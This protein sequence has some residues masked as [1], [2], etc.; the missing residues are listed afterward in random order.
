[1]KKS[2]TNSAGFGTVE[3]LLIVLLVGII[4]IAGWKV[5]DSNK[6]PTQQAETPKTSSAAKITTTYINKELGFK[7]VY[8]KKWGEP[9]LSTNTS[10]TGTSYSI[11]IYPTATNTTNKVVDFWLNSEDYT[12]QGASDL[13]P[14]DMKSSTKSSVL[15]SIGEYTKNPPDYAK[16]AYLGSKSYI[17]AYGNGNYGEIDRLYASHV[18]EI[19]KLNLSAIDGRYSAVLDVNNTQKANCTKG[20]ISTTNPAGLCITQKEVNEFKTALQS[21]EAID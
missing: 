10:I 8:P 7:F 11:S 4:G 16:V 13:G 6:S 12:D 17:L 18:V 19:P 2:L 21:F 15:E 9:Q 5:Y 14:R 3:A 20:E 1:M